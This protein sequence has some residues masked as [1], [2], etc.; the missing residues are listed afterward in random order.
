MKVVLLLALGLAA[1]GGADDGVA[2]EQRLLAWP[3]AGFALDLCD[4]A[5]AEWRA[6]S[7]RDRKERS[8]APRCCRTTPGA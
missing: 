7:S 2:T 8:L 4:M 5:R 1:C 3:A 6:I